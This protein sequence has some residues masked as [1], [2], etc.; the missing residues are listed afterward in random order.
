MTNILAD[1]DFL[2]DAFNPVA[3]ARGLAERFRSRRLELNITQ[4]GL[5]A[6]SGVSL[7]SVKRFENNYEISLKHLLM[8]AVVLD[9]TEEFNT[10]FS[11]KHY[12]SIEEVLTGAASKNRK[13]GRRNV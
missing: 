7:G 2:L 3:I 10:L 8:L 1:K 13:R 9:S 4:Q 5:A 11:E 12:E 6:K